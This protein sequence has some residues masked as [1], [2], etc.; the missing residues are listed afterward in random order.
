MGRIKYFILIVLL[1]PAFFYGLNIAL[2]LGVGPLTGN[3]T[4][5]LGGISPTLAALFLLFRY[6]GREER[7]DFFRRIWDP[8]R[9]PGTQ[10]AVIV[11][12]PPAVLLAGIGLAQLA[13]ST[14]A[15]FQ[16][17]SSLFPQWWSVIP[18]VLFILFL[19]PIPEEIGWRGYLLD[20]LTFRMSGWK[21]SLIVALVWSLWHVPLFFIEGYPLR[22]KL[23]DPAA[24]TLYFALLFPVSQVYTWVFYRTGRSILAAILFHFFINFFGTM[25]EADATTDFISL[26]LWTAAALVMIRSYPAI[27]RKPVS[28]WKNIPSS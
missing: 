18:F 6:A 2:G 25:W 12:L 13:G 20:G 1:W 22:E 5:A 28:Q 26:I 15:T 10:W 9:I 16:A 4:V 27:F 14:E 3:L 7:N 19:G 23:G 21:A 24:L 11:L 8:K 17:E